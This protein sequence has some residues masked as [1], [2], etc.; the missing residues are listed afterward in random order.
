MAVSVS[1]NPADCDLRVTT[2]PVIT[3][4]RNNGLNMTFPGTEIRLNGFTTLLGSPGDSARGWTAGILQAEWAETNWCSYRGACDTDGSIFIQRGRGP[5]R[6]QR[7]CRDCVDGVPINAVFYNTLPGAGEVASGMDDAPFPQV[8]RVRHYDAPGDECPLTLRN[9]LT[10]KGNLLREVQFEFMFCAT[11]SVRDPAGAFRHMM[12]VYW[13][14]RWQ[15]RFEQPGYRA[16]VNPAGTGC[17][18]GSVFR[19]DPHD[20]RFVSVLTSPTETRSCNDIFR[21]ASLAF[22]P[23]SPNR[24]ESRTWTNFVVTAP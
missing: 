21:T 2:A 3:P 24:H 6:S 13:N 1:S 11:L 5:A 7:A 9:S 15:Y 20:R 22:N 14:T 17:T 10:G 8:L 4:P 12:G 16:V 23:G 19:G 18:V